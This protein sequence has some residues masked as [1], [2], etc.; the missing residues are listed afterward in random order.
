[1]RLK[2]IKMKDFHALFYQS[3]V[4]GMQKYSISQICVY[5]CNVILL[6]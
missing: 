2:I 3:F 5:F 4:K 6:G 1:M